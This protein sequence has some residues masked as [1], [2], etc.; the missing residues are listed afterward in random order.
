MA[1]TSGKKERPRSAYAG[2]RP[3]KNEGWGTIA[4]TNRGLG[5]QE[6]AKDE[7]DAIVERLSAVSSETKVPDSQRTGAMKQSG[8][9][10]SYAWKGY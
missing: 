5:Y 8:I 2:T 10:N 7:V 6:R 9:M 1:S 3:P 4:E